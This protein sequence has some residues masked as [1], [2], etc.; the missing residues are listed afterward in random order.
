MKVFNIGYIEVAHIKEG[1]KLLEK[2]RRETYDSIKE[3]EFPEGEV[4]VKAHELAHVRTTAKLLEDMRL[5]ELCEVCLSYFWDRLKEE[6]IDNPDV[7]YVA[8]MI[9][10]DEEELK[11]L[12]KEAGYEED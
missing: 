8:D 1:L 9:G 4:N 5:Q 6:G 7:E 2:Q 12:F 11:M 10:I 3:M